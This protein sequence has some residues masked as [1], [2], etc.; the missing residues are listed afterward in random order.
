[1][2]LLDCVTQCSEDG[3]DLKSPVL[4]A[5]AGSTPVPSIIYN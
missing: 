5:G 2:Q 1:M 4:I 3:A